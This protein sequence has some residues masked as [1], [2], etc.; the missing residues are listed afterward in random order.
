MT[1]PTYR[2]PIGYRFWV[3]PE[4][5]LETPNVCVMASGQPGAILALLMGSFGFPV[6]LEEICAFLH[7]DREDGGPLSRSR[8]VAVQVC[9]L[10]MMLRQY[11]IAIAVKSGGRGNQYYR[12]DGIRPCDP[13]PGIFR[14]RMTP[15]SGG[16]PLRPREAVCPVDPSPSKSKRSKG[17][18]KG[19]RM[20]NPTPK[21]YRDPRAE[22]LAEGGG[23]DWSFPPRFERRVGSGVVSPTT[24]AEAL[25]SEV[26]A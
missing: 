14:E 6:P 13:Q 22:M 25:R 1:D 19:R 21:P 18:R 9:R 15:K 23:A 7:D 3:Y 11:G 10:K 12:L 26:D 4:Y 2:L 5:R 24:P 8:G 16:H 20:P 17:V